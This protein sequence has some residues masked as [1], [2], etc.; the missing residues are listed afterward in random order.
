MLVLALQFSRDASDS[1]APPG[2]DHLEEVTRGRRSDA[3]DGRGTS[4]RFSTGEAG[5]AGR[6][7][8][9]MRGL[10]ERGRRTH[11]ASSLTTEQER[12]APRAPVVPLLLPRASP[13][14]FTGSE[15]SEMPNNQ[16]ST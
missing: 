3:A 9:A 8:T 14:G 5:A 7:R 16:C 15:V 11:G 4:P 6:A 1:F 12:P 13:E 10:D 2:P